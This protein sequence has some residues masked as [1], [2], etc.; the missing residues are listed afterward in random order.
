MALK[1]LEIERPAG[2]SQAPGEAKESRIPVGELGLG[3][4]TPGPIEQKKVTRF[5]GTVRLDPERV[6]RDMATVSSE[7]VQHLVGLLGAE[8]ELTLE[9]QA[10][11][12]Q[13]IPENI[14]RT[15]SENCRTLKFTTQ[16]FEKE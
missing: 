13:G 4:P 9:L 5:Y 10:S 7:V 12:P 2:I 16:S 14:I 8:V 3:T 15:V 6:N 1:Q 11:V